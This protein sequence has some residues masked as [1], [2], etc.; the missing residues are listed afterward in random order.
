VAAELDLESIESSFDLESNLEC[1]DP[2]LF[3]T[4]AGVVDF[5]RSAEFEGLSYAVE[6][7]VEFPSEHAGGDETPEVRAARGSAWQLAH[8]LGVLARAAVDPIEPC[9]AGGWD[10]QQDLRQLISSIRALSLIARACAS[11]PMNETCASM[12]DVPVLL[13]MLV[14]ATA[15]LEAVE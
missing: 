6:D 11:E 5:V 12:A 2:A 3:V 8:D 15:R 14:R 1:L 7:F 4:H 9:C 10:P 13:E